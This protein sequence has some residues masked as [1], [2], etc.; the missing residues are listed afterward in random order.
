[1]EDAGFIVG[2]Y[3]VTFATVALV[4]WRFVRHGRRLAKQVSDDDKYW[5]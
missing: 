1:M 5:L 2:S 3:V 4:A